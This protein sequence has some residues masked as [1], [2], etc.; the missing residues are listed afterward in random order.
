MKKLLR[1]LFNAFR[2]SPIVLD[3][4]SARR[5]EMLLSNLGF[6]V[7]SPRHRGERVLPYFFLCTRAARE[8]SSGLGSA[9]QVQPPGSQTRVPLEQSTK[10]YVADDV[11][12]HRSRPTRV[13]HKQ[14]RGLCARTAYT[15]F[16]LSPSAP[17]GVL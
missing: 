16:S 9:V 8:R 12:Q 10:A 11:I 17:P 5:S 14:L 6:W 15:A 13:S 7:G 3:H 1:L 2:F 4:F